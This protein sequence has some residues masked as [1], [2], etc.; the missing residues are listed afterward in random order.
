MEKHFGQGSS[1][2]EYSIKRHKGLGILLQT[3]ATL[4]ASLALELP[5]GFAKAVVEHSMLLD[6]SL[7]LIPLSCPPFPRCYYQGTA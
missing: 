2:N 1:L 4:K 7:N 3:G 5:V 6:F